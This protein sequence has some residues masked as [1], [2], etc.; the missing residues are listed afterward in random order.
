MKLIVGLGNPSSEHQYNRHNLGFMALDGLF[1]HYQFEDW[2]RKFSGVFSAK[3]L[4]SDKVI[5]V[6]PQT[7]MNLSGFCVVKFKHFFKVVNDDIFVI[8]DDIDLELGHIKFKKGGGDAGHKGVRS[9]SQHL[10]TKDFN[11]I[12]LG[13]GRPRTKEEVSSFVLS[14]FSKSETDRTNTL[15]QKLCEGFEEI[16]QKKANL[17]HQG[18]I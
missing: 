11:R 8:Y 9:I 1:T 18:Y 7:Y 2:K 5:L 10:G 12:R 16:I 6:K 13:I 4:G 3:L 14:N 17:T 15:I